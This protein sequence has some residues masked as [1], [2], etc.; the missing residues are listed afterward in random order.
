LSKRNILDDLKS[1]V[2]NLTDA[3]AKLSDA[4]EEKAKAAVQ[5]ALDNLNKIIADAKAVVE[6][7][8]AQ[9]KEKVKEIADKAKEVVE[10]AVKELSDLKDKAEAKIASYIEELKT[11]GEAAVSCAYSKWGNIT[12]VVGSAGKIQGLLCSSGS[13]GRNKTYDVVLRRVRLNIAAVEKQQILHICMCV[14]ERA[15][16]CE[17]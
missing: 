10:N 4:A 17:P 14:R 3:A 15:C 8:V 6:N 12:S 13:I 7:A 11:Y 5:E 1:K 2:Q 16:V 9:I